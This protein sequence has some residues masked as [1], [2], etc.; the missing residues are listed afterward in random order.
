[1][2]YVGWSLM[3][4]DWQKM[5]FQELNHA[6][7]KKTRNSIMDNIEPMMFEGVFVTV[8]NNTWGNITEEDNNLVDL[9]NQR[10]IYQES[11]CE[12]QIPSNFKERVDQKSSIKGK[13]IVWHKYVFLNLD[14]HY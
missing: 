6:A 3:M 2:D 1:M 8:K 14:Q 4:K 12:L 10:F 11:T 7:R 9:F 13:N 5:K